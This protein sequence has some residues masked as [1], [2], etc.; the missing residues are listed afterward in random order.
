[1]RWKVLLLEQGQGQAQIFTEWLQSVNIECSSHS[2]ADSAVLALKDQSFDAV[3]MGCD[4]EDGGYAV[5][6]RLRYDLHSPSPVL[7]IPTTKSHKKIT[8]T[9]HAGANDFLVKPFNQQTF[10]NCLSTLI[11]NYSTRQTLLNCYPYEFDELHQDVL[12]YGKSLSLS[13]TE[14]LLSAYLF[15]FR[16]RIVLS[17]DLARE[18]WND[19]TP[20]GALA[21]DLQAMR[22]KRRL[23]F[24]EI[25]SW[26][27]QTLNGIGYRL[28]SVS[29]IKPE[30]SLHPQLQAG[31]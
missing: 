3:I 6:N 9:L 20:A 8:D 12:L 10:L 26:K 28:N 22:L 19:T 30:Q 13:P 25:D 24:K 14:Y 11:E 29:N 31:G 15:Y 17:S 2:T 4:P 1:M 7:Y 5:L 16:N 21:V 18:L 27:L 23:R